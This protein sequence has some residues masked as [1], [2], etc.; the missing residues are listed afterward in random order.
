MSNI[1]ETGRT[2]RV[3][4]RLVVIQ[5]LVFSL[6]L[7]LGGRLWYLQ[8][9]NGQEYSAEARNNHVQQVVQPAV[10][11]SIYDARGV[12]IADNETKL[13]V[14]ANRTDLMRMSDNGKAVLTRL[15]GVLGMKPADVIAKVR[16]C[17]AKTPKPCWN[18]S[19]YQPIPVTETA[20]TQQ[21][22]QIRERTED[23]P[24]ITAEP[25]AVRSYPGTGGLNA[26]QVL[27]YLGPV[28]DQEVAKSNK[29]NN[30]L[31]RSDQV[32]RAG[33][34]STYDQQLR[35][36]S[37]VTRYEVDNLGRV[38]GKAGQT[39]SQPGSSLV[40]SIDS[41]VQAL[42]EKELDA[43][44]KS[45]RKTYDSV[46]HS[47]Y[48]ADSGAA[49]VMDVHTG[50]VIAMASAPT[51]NPNVWGGGIS[52]KNY[53][54]LTKASSN[55]PLLNRAIQGQS[56]P[57]STFKVIS[58]SAAINAGYAPDGGYPCTSSMTIGNREFKNFEGENYGSI[59]LG[60]ALEV[61]CDTVFYHLAYDQWKKDGG[62][63]P[64]HPKD[65][66]FKTAR[67]FGLGKKTGIDLPDEL[68]GRVPD[69]DWKK[70]YWEANKDVWCKQGKKNGTY[71]EQIEYENCTDGKQVRAG[72]SVNYAIGQGDTLLT[73]VQE[74]MIYSAIA[75]GGTM[76]QPS[77]GKAI[78][79]ADG[80]TVQPMKPKR[81]GRL[82]DTKST[83]SYI[84]KALEG[85]VTS[86]TAAW[87]FGG[88]PQNKIPLHAKTG[89]AEVA[90]KQTTGW[91]ATYTKDYAIVMTISQGGTGSGSAGPAVR[92]I[93]EAMYG[94]GKDGKQDPKKALLPKPQT[95]L[96]KINKDG[97][98]ISPKITPPKPD[99]SPPAPSP[100]SSGGQQIAAGP[101]R[102]D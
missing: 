101:G 3:R 16:L 94:I 72:D 18:G 96:P 74:A 5:V 20:T 87:Q 23:F 84:D 85:V 41:R 71:V 30:P 95:A 2:S 26:A 32:G 58:T 21:A 102:K 9:R 10:R 44:M 70:A 68:A 88:W 11:G 8:I 40:T 45:L 100:S 93:Y 54:E 77:V 76:Y 92:K 79:S 78:I 49:V 65:W 91:L 14:S 51:Y 50:Q 63:N 81:I 33:L 64:K 39:A 66:F 12:P 7:T 42:T 56:A 52:A 89:T 47:N 80:R 53:A 25:T 62:N 35:G 97:T 99:P 15:A 28:T 48:K 90:G 1:P 29:T 83:V 69:R 4:I 31:L 19:P 98:I 75:N 59:S 55:Y 24:G 36:K 17:D 43:T 86:G 38:I 46:T 27:G 22:L 67:E 37:G 13:V 61:S 60:K 57:G 73:P 6:L 34:E 82:P